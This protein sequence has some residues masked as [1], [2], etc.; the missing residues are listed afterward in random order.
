MSQQLSAPLRETA[1]N[2]GVPAARPLQ[3]G[4]KARAKRGVTP[5]GAIAGSGQPQAVEQPETARG[6]RR[7]KEVLAAVAGLV[8]FI[9]ALE[10]LR[11]ELRTVS[12]VEL[13]AD[14]LRVPRTALA[15][16][17]GLTVLNYLVLTGYDLIA[18]VYI[19]K[20]LSRVRVMLTSFLAYAVANNVSF[21]ML[22]GASVRYRFYSRWG[23]TPGE[24]SRIVFSY[25]VTFWLGLFALGGLS[26]LVMP[27]TVSGPLPAGQLATVAGWAL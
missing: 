16:A 1:M 8:L 22:S 6:N 14:V 15:L 2:N 11:I 12:W 24:L 10:V 3:A 26:L 20:H 27:L 7:C 13:T 18:F 4:V 5:A 19:G 25:S 21:A 9:A 17:I 23:V